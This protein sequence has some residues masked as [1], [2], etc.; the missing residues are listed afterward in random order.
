M[1]TLY[2]D[3]ARASGVILHPFALHVALVQALYPIGSTIITTMTQVP[4]AVISTAL[5]VGGD[6]SAPNIWNKTQVDA[7]ACSKRAT[8]PATS[9]ITANSFAKSGR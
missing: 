3:D 2:D 6:L 9:T 4:G 1:I 8:I 7:I 5:S